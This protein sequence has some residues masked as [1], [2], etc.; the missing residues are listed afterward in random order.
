VARSLREGI[1]YIG[2][3]LLG[4]AL[5]IPVGAL[6]GAGIAGIAV[7]VPAGVL[8]SGWRRLG[9][10]AAQVTFTALFALLLGGDQPVHYI[11]HR[12]I[13]SRHWRGHRP[14]GQHHRVPAAPAPAGRARRRAVG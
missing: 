13:E 3:F 7:I 12:M 10:Q 5:A 2:G 8:L 11:T 9:D 4:A 1:Q 6:L 14:C